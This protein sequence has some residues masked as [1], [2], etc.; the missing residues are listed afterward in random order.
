MANASSTFQKYINHTLRDFLDDF[1]S[2]YI[3]DILI[4][5]DGSLAQHKEQVKRV[6]QHLQEAGLQIDID[7]CEFHVQST[8]Y[9][10]FILEAG[11]GLQMD[12][13]KVS[14]LQ[15]WEAPTSVRAVQAF[16]GFANFYRHFIKDFSRIAAP[17]TGLMKKDTVFQWS[18]DCNQA[19]KFLKDTFIKAPVLEQFD[20]DHK[21]VL[22]CDTSG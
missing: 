22:A 19:F 20:M 16:L 7:K 9:L 10:G 6:L 3:D 21:T 11:K 1:C 8:K 2:A 15:A 5:T 14:A 4:Y 12:P 13:E 17:L 18:P